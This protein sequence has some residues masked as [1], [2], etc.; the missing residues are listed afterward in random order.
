MLTERVVRDTKPD[1][2]ARTIWDK[3]VMGLGLQV[4]PKGVKNYIIRYRTGDRKRQ[5]II[6]RAGQV[7]LAE[8]RKRAGAE[9]VKIRNGE[10]AGPL[11]RREAEQAAPTVAEGVTRFFD[12]YV[13]RRMAD[14][15]L[16]E[17]TLYDYRKQAGRTILPALGERKIRDVTRHDI[18]RAVASRGPVQRNRT[19]ALLSRIFALFET[20]ELRPQNSNPVRGIEKAREEPRD[21][22]L[23]PS[24]IQALAMALDGIDD[25][26]PAACV[27]FLLMTGWRSGEAL[28][29]QW[30]DINFETGEIVLASTKTGR[31]VRTVA[32]L[33]L[34]LLND[35]PRINN[36]PHVFA[37]ARG[38]A[39]S[40]K[41]LRSCFQRACRAAGLE[42]VRLHD[43]RRSVATSAAASGL[44]VFLLRDLL[45]HRSISMANR[46]ARRAGSALQEAHD[47]SAERMAA[48]MAGKQGEEVSMR[49][50][51]HGG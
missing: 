10:T 46:Y 12:E 32:G 51:R 9:L 28:A 21:R 45:N 14:G 22:V 26:F 11:E 17:R 24:E 40:Y 27:R 15:R 42:D 1:G 43:I 34:D 20:W 33:A 30:H 47:A 50:R 6:A 16:S 8:A 23:A 2:K 19:L 29:L 3:Q 37:G 25:P 36:N 38:V 18:E 35:V 48:I 7:S 5:A 13:P 49:G 4:T 41:T 31:Q 39:I 44:S